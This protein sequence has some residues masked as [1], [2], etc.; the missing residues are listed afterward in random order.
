LQPFIA[1]AL[2]TPEAFNLPLLD[3]G[4]PEFVVAD[5]KGRIVYL[6]GKARRLLTLAAHTDIGSGATALEP[7]VL[8]P[9]VVRICENFAGVRNGENTAEAPA[10]HHRTIWGG[11]TFRASRLDPTE[12]SSSLVGVTIAHREPLP[13]R[14]AWQ[15]SRLPLT[16]RQ[17]EV[18]FLMAVGL[19]YPEIAERLG[20]SPHT[21]VAHRRWVYEKLEVSNRTELVNKLLASREVLSSSREAHR[22]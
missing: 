17:S 15:V 12:A 21:A 7:P 1:Y 13:M 16:P 11:F 10:Y 14:L 22:S 4:H 18:C 19:S 5:G 9:E 6:S 3:S 2:S 20:I 8:P